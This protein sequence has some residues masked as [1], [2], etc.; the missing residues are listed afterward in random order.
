MRKYDGNGESSPRE[1]DAVA[2]TMGPLYSPSIH[3]TIFLH[4]TPLLHII[5]FLY[6]L[7]LLYILSSKCPLVFII[8]HKITIYYIYNQQRKPIHNCQ[9]VYKNEIVSHCTQ[10]TCVCAT[11]VGRV[12]HLLVF[13][14]T[15]LMRLP[16]IVSSITDAIQ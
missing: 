12:C 4:Y 14:N 6:I 13:G 11:R 2:A 7:L 1:T 3:Y 9:Q 8:H 16:T 15:R 10:Y 5:L